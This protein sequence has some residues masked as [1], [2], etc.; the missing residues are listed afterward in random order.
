MRLELVRPREQSRFANE[1]EYHFRH[2]LV[3]EA[4]YGMLVGPDR[5]L[6]HR[7][8]A[9][10]LEAAGETEPL[11]LAEHHERGGEPQRAAGWYVEAAEVALRGSDVETTLRR[12][13]QALAC[14]PPPALL[15]RLHR[16]QDRIHI[17]L[18]Y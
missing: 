8:A 14:G 7:L 10:W 3:R 4:A 16:L 18:A 2:G 9:A 17:E 13:E 15:G 12:L 6:G 11:V 1:P 5:V